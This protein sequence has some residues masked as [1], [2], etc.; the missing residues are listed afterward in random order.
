MFKNP[1]IWTI[2]TAIITAL[3]YIDVF[4]LDLFIFTIP[5]AVVIALISTIVAVKQK[6]YIYIFFNIPLAI[7]ACACYVIFPW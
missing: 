4:Y 5:L 2:I 3:V 1:A 7:I 6:Q